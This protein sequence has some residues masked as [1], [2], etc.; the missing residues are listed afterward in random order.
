[1]KQKQ[2]SRCLTIPQSFILYFATAC[3]NPGNLWN[4]SGK[5]WSNFQAS[6]QFS[7]FLREAHLPCTTSRKMK[8]CIWSYERINQ[9]NWFRVHFFCEQ[10]VCIAALLGNLKYICD[11]VELC[12]VMG[13]VVSKI[14][15]KVSVGNI[16][17]KI[18]WIVN[19]LWR[20][21]HGVICFETE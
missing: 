2:N 1:M 12:A 10:R 19:K 4:F 7:I 9:P 5:V 3:T 14:E 20:M 21:S 13:K 6:E 18:Y 15:E 16:K 11:R 8:R 17:I